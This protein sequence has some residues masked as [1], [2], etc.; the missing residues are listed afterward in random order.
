MAY[1]Q[2]LLVPLMLL[3][4]YYLTVLGAAQRQKVYAQH[5]R[6]QHY[7][8]NPLWQRSNARLQRFNPRHILL[9]L[10]VSAALAL[11]AGDPTS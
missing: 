5:F 7:E 10:L 6:T 9:V 8:L 11:V 4:D 1:P 2:V 3:A